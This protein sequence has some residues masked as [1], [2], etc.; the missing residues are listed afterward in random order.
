MNANELLNRFVAWPYDAREYIRRPILRDGWVYATNGHIMVRVPWAEDI[1]A[2]E[3]AIPK[4]MSF[5]LDTN[6]RDTY[7]EFPAIPPAEACAS[8]SGFGSAYKCPNCGRTGEFCRGDEEYQCKR[9]AGSGQVDAGDE[10]NVVPC[11]ACEGTGKWLYQPVQVGGTRFA[12][13]YM[14]LIGSLPGVKF[15][16]HP[17][18]EYAPAYFVFDGGEGLLMSMRK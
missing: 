18:S 14:D 12:R 2:V 3:S 15:A 8:C 13:R 16:P 6:R 11:D 17:I 1:D 7:V 10:A 9:C 5:L 4:G